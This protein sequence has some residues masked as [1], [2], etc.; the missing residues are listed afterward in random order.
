MKNNIV[1]ERRAKLININILTRVQESK[2][3]GQLSFAVTF[4][5]LQLAIY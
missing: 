1:G 5:V 2:G 3:T 4:A